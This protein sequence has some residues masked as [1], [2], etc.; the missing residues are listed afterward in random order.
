MSP[1]MKEFLDKLDH[2]CW[3]YSYEIKPTHPVPLGEYPTIT[4][5]GNAETTKVLYIDGDGIG[6]GS[7]N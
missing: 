1:K 2:L 7:D 4:I 3:E 5:M 6:I